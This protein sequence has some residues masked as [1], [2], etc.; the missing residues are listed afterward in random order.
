M[1]RLEGA[2]LAKGEVSA[3]RWCEESVLRILENERSFYVTMEDGEIRLRRGAVPGLWYNGAVLEAFT[4][5]RRLSD[6]E[7]ELLTFDVMRRYDVRFTMKQ[8]LRYYYLWLK[9]KIRR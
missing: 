2:R 6:D 7:V 8:R 3:M 4:F 9:R 1:Y 5:P